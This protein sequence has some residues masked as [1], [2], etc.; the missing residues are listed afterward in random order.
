MEKLHGIYGFMMKMM[1][2]TVGK[3]MEKKRKPHVGGRGYVDAVAS[4]RKQSVRR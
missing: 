2:N 4:W 3:G 1:K